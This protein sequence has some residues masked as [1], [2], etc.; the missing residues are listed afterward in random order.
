MNFRLSEAAR[1]RLAEL[2]TEWGVNATAVLERLLSEHREIEVSRVGPAVKK[3]L[4]DPLRSKKAKT[5]RGEALT[6][7]NVRRV[8][9]PVP[10]WKLDKLARDG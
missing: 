1:L 6:S 3:V 9:I 4:S 10:Q 7:P 8:K 5:E 2:S